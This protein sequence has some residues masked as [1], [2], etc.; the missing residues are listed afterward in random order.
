MKCKNFNNPELILLEIIQKNIIQPWLIY[1]S[2]FQLLLDTDIAS[3]MNYANLMILMGFNLF[4]YY[5]D[6]FT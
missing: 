4:T 5:K 3:Q 2:S 1:L 6:T